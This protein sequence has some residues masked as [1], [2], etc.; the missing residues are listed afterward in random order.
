M[1]TFLTS[2]YYLNFKQKNLNTQLFEV[3]RYNYSKNTISKRKRKKSGAFN[4][5]KHTQK[6]AK[7][8]V[9]HYKSLEHKIYTGPE[10]VTYTL[11]VMFVKFRRSDK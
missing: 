10:N 3:R 11:F 7:K 8:K 2:T 9:I 5:K 6:Y 1:V 4:K